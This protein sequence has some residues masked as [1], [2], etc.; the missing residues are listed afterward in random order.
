MNEFEDQEYSSDFELGLWKRLFYHIREHKKLIFKIMFLF[1]LLAVVETALPMFSAF[2]I[3]NFIVGGTLEGLP[4][5]IALYFVVIL[6]F[7]SL[8]FGFVLTAGKLE[9]SIVHT[10][11]RKG[12]EKLQQLSYSF[13]DTTPVGYIMA[14]MTSDAQRL[15]DTVAWAMMELVW[16]LAM[17]LFMIIVML[18]ISPFLTMI[19]LAVMPLLFIITIL[20][21]KI[22]LKNQRLIRKQNSKIT[23]AIAEGINAA[24]TTKT[25]IRESKNFEEF[26][27]L[28]TKMKR[29]S[30]RAAVISAAFYPIIVLIANVAVGLVVW[31][32]GGQVLVDQISLGTMSLFLNFTMLMFE[33]I[34][35]MARVFSEIQSAQASAERTIGLI[36]TEPDI[37][38]TP[39]VVEKY[40][41]LL[42]PKP[43]NWP[44]LQGDIVFDNVSFSYKTGE[45][46]LE[47][48][49]LHI[50]AGEKIALVGETGAGKST[51]INLVCHFY[52]PTGGRILIDGVDYRKY[53]QILLQS[54]LGYVLQTPHLFSGTIKENIRYGKLEATDEEVVEAANTVNAHDFISKL[55][56]GFDTE[57]GE[58]GSKISTGEKQLISFA[59]AILKNPKIFVLDEATSSIDTVTEQ[60]IQKAVDKV[61][62]N[63][64]S[65]IV[66]H[67]LSTIR[68]ADRI[69]VIK[70]GKIFEQGNHK[71]LIKKRG[72]YYDLYTTQFTKEESER[73]LNV[74]D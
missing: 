55:E 36:D 51:I 68:S 21:R 34:M 49:N 27:G 38:D 4:Q 52:E 37:S 13:Y 15:G 62:K 59:R 46:V 20:F 72:Y 26:D 10:I 31:N 50:K 45:Q 12:F 35:Q 41:S 14:R 8:V 44:V 29:L 7:C 33:P 22:M 9:T 19:V 57:V 69:L 1:I 2:A 74:A 39:E 63:R 73:I 32:A 23:A 70:N 43:E 47:N 6:A 24:R 67:R 54:N 3:D 5:F 56:H 66:A 53:S 71:E 40:G 64:T 30:V 11:R 25:L 60:L 16:S 48:F 61:L 18:V 65:F 28:T 42:H 17:M 58:G